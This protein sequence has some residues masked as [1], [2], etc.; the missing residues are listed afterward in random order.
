MATLSIYLAV[1]HL[2]FSLRLFVRVDY[3]PLLLNRLT[4][5]L[6]TLP[7]DEAVS[8]V[9]QFMNTYSISQEDYDT[10]MELAK[11]KGRANPLEGV[12]PALPGVKKAPKKRIA[13]MLEPTV[14]SLSGEDGEPVAEN[15]EENE[16][17]AEDSDAFLSG[18]VIEFS[19][20]NMFSDAGGADARRR[21][22]CQ[23]FLATTPSL[24]HFCPVSLMVSFNFAALDLLST[25]PVEISVV[26]YCWSEFTRVDLFSRDSWIIFSDDTSLHL[27][28]L[29][30][31]SHQIFRS[32]NLFNST[33]VIKRLSED[34][35]RKRL[36]P[37]LLLT[38]CVNP[39]T[40]VDGIPFRQPD[41][42]LQSLIRLCCLLNTLT[43]STRLS[44]IL[45]SLAWKSGKTC[46]GEEQSPPPTCLDGHLACSGE[47]C[48][49]PPTTALC[50][51]TKD[52]LAASD[53]YSRSTTS[54]ANEL[55]AIG[56]RY[57]SSWAW[58]STL[59]EAAIPVINLLKSRNLQHIET[60]F[61]GFIGSV[62]VFII[63]LG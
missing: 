44:Y 14:E 13:A 43:F 46:Y 41:L 20:F 22:L 23:S 31:S 59:A 12:P 7:K 6:Q 58:P 10:I 9:V 62:I 56:P 39:A 61:G 38:F 11:F 37:H 36:Q 15:E 19:N 30:V 42:F 32:I 34:P 4:S 16:S 60:V 54:L 51:S 2:L 29:H 35:H 45:S 17:D 33:S 21:H 49:Y 63:L 27:F 5:P 8:E 48:K 25:L 53:S 50:L 1:L 47:L 24:I 26:S 3:L 28:I 57:E 55:E 52:L 40:D 18:T